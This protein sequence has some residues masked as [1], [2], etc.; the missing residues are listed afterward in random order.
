MRGD[1][2]ESFAKGAATV[3]RAMEPDRLW[4]SPSGEAFALHGRSV[5]FVRNVGHLMT[6]P[7]IKLPNG[8]EAPADPC[9]AVIPLPCSPH[10]GT[11][12]ETPNHSPPG[13]THLDKPTPNQPQIN[14]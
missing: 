6:T 3:T 13:S 4:T 9:D 14:D 10:D 12:H 2:V 1:L 7:M 11:G 8:A 5:M